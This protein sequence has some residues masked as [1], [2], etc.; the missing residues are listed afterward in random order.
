[1]TDK[2]TT[3]QPPQQTERL[4]EAGNIEKRGGWQKPTSEPTPAAMNQA[5]GMP[6][7]P[8]GNA[9]GQDNAGGQGGQAQGSDK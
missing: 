9:G 6:D 3:P 2:D 1:M 8:H 4:R 7:K 5:Q